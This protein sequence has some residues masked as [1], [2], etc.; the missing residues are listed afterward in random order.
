MKIDAGLVGDVDTRPAAESAEA[1]GFDGVWSGEVAHDPFIGLSLAASVTER[2][3]VGSSIAVSFARNPMS[4][5]VIANDLQALSRGRFTLGLGSQVKAHI[6]RRYSMPWTDPVARMREYICAV[7]AIWQSWGEGTSL[8]FRGEYYSHTLMP[9]MFR[10]EPH[11][12]GWPPVV[13]AGVGPAM[14]R[15]AGDVADGFICHSFST[16][17]YVRSVT[18]PALKA[19]RGGDLANFCVIGAPFIAVGRTEAELH[20]AVDFVRAQIAFYAS[21]PTYR[22]ILDVHGW[23]SLGEELHSLSTTSRWQEMAGLIDDQVLN[24]LAAV[25]KPADVG[26]VLGMRYRG[27]FDRMVLAVAYPLAP[28]VLTEVAAC[29]KEATR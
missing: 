23:G 2:L 14:T 25:G 17:R 24:A 18:L 20:T 21:T 5:A 9:P 16:E 29:A 1:Q 10:P 22:R 26:R 13:L 15:L 4:V 6:T 7:K 27:V 11:D 3:H 8:D 19:A 12:Y 28:D